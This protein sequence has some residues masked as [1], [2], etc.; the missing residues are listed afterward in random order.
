MLSKKLYLVFGL[1]AILTALIVVFALDRTQTWVALFMLPFVLLLS[2]SYVFSPQID[3][4]WFQKHPPELSGGLSNLLLKYFPFYQNLSKEN[5]KR[6]R[7]RTAMY[8]EAR[9]FYAKMGEESTEVP[10]DIKTIIS[11]NIVMLTFGQKD[12][13]LDQFER[14][15]IYLQAFHSPNYKFWHSSELNEEDACIMFSG[16]HIMVSFRQPRR[17]YNLVLHEFARAFQISYPKFDYPEFDERM[18][19]DLGKDAILKYLGMP[20]EEIDKIGIG[21]NCFFR[22]PKKFKEEM[23]RAFEKFSSIFNLNPLETKNPVVD[24]NIIANVP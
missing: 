14:I 21:V 20:E 18:W 19:D 9:G 23:P 2:L 7:H 3:W 4:W 22:N 11:A 8:M 17:G 10:A 15:F 6:F 12:F 1:G 24:K 13:I 16:E 5:K